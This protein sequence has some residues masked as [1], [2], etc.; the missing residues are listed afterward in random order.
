MEKPFEQ[1]NFKR[2]GLVN[3]SSITQS[4]GL[5]VREGTVRE[6]TVVHKGN[7]KYSGP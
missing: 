2:R 6:V 7:V 3:L 4:S 1:E 5:W